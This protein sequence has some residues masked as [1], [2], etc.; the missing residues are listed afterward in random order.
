MRLPDMPPHGEAREEA[1][2]TWNAY[3]P[4]PEVKARAMGVIGCKR[5]LLRRAFCPSGSRGS[6]V[7][8]SIGLIEDLLFDHSAGK[9]L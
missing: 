5:T 4:T 6:S 9:S 8:R 3:L 1:E 7:T 2:T